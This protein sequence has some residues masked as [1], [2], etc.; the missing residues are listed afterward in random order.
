DFNN[1]IGV[2]TTAALEQLDSS[3]LDDLRIVARDGTVL[4]VNLSGVG[5]LQDIADAING[6]VG[7]NAGTTAVL[8]RLSSDGNRIELVD[9]STV[10]TGTFRVEALAGKHAAEYLGFVPEGAAQQDSTSTDSVG[11][12][13]LTGRNVVG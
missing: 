11:N 2:P 7:N 9:S 13:L 8:A 1:G 3:K 10:T 4:Q 5:S 12:S 6:A